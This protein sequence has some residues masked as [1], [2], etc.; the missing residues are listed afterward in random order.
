MIFEDI[1][2]LQELQGDFDALKKL[3]HPQMRQ[4]NPKQNFKAPMMVSAHQLKHLNKIDQL[5]TDAVIIN[6]E[7]GVAAEKKQEAL[8]YAL[9]FISHLQKSDKK[10]IVRVNPLEEG[11]IQEI[12]AL[13]KVYPDAIRVAKIK[14]ASDVLLVERLVDSSIDIHLSIE[15]AT[16][17]KELASLKVSQRVSHFYLGILDLLADLGLSQNIISMKNPSMLYLLSHFLI[18]CKSIGVTPV[19]FVYQEHLNHEAFQSWVELEQQ[20]GFTS[21]GVISPKQAQQMMD[22]VLD[23][24]EL[25]RALHIISRFE[26]HRKEGVTG[27][28]DETYGF[29]DEPIY[30]G[31][32]I[33]KDKHGF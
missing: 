16:A 1:Q 8:H 21:K 7:D 22:L 11:G 15:T 5:Y 20:M 19:S 23:P 28:V 24:Q 33:V 25:E 10:I 6:L 26:S 4:Q 14:S 12:K 31:A 17:W 9:L 3:H 18:T 29:I 27:F 2:K 30:K 13:N 32:L